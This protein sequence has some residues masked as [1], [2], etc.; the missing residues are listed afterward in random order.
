[1]SKI[2]SIEFGTGYVRVIALSKMR[3]A[4]GISAF[5]EREIPLS[6]E[7]SGFP[8]A[9]MVEAISEIFETHDLSR[10]QVA[11]SLPAHRCVFRYFAVDFTSD[12]AIRK[13]IKYAAEEHLPTTSIENVI[14][15]YY[16]LGVEKGKTHLLVS[17]VEKR[18]IKS[19]L[20]VLESCRIDPLTIDIDLLAS[21]NTY[22]RFNL[23]RKPGRI[24]LVEIGERSSNI[25]LVVDGQLQ[26]LRSPKLGLAAL[27]GAG[28]TLDMSEDPL[29]SL[30]LSGDLGDVEL[31]LDGLE[32]DLVIS[33]SS[34]E[35]PSS[36][37]A[38]AAQ[39]PEDAQQEL[40]DRHRSRFLDRL[41]KDLRRTVLTARKGA[42]EAIYLTGPG[43]QLEDVAELLEKKFGVPVSTP[44]FLDHIPHKLNGVDLEQANA[45]LPNV[46]GL[47]LKL[48]GMDESGAELRKE[49]FK[50]SRKFEQIQ[51]ALVMAVLL[52]FGIVL[53]VC[54]QFQQQ[55]YV[56][57]KDYHAVLR[58]ARQLVLDR[59]YRKDPDRGET[60]IK[61]L[62]LENKFPALVDDLDALRKEY[63]PDGGEGETAIRPVLDVWLD[64]FSGLREFARRH[65]DQLFVTM[66]EIKADDIRFSAT[67]SRGQEP[68]LWD[69]VQAIVAKHDYMERGIH[70]GTQRS[71]DGER[72][73]ISYRIVL[74]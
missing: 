73:S 41:V 34:L 58:P 59:W 53:L 60:A 2:V 37:S 57:K 1:M 18:L 55:L 33:I 42:P 23:F 71:K 13:T 25:S 72:L 11:L 22:K 44:Q 45:L 32:K 5:E 62:K 74:K 52:L 67:V 9:P 17:I 48:L 46:L 4:W 16:K 36:G 56:A 26:F 47:G 7:N 69:V 29:Q 6:D 66:F 30:D 8:E 39:S 54:Y 10:D 24:M 50:F 63:N 49:E 27:Q 20:Q 61:E 65:P 19:A 21:L 38:Q 43:S 3:K 12:D 28:E 31:D 68:K 14:V 15:N 40:E 35:D 51:S 64:F 70:G